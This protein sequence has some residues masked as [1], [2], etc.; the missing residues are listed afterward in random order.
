MWCWWSP[1]DDIVRSRFSNSGGGSSN[2]LLILISMIMVILMIE[3]SQASLV[4]VPIVFWP[5]I[6]LNH[7][8]GMTRWYRFIM[9]IILSSHYHNHVN[10]ST[11]IESYKLVSIVNMIIITIII[12]I[13]IVII[14]VIV[15]V[16]IMITIII[17]IIII[18]VII[19]I[20]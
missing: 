12:I 7:S 10:N 19:I 2:C 4:G 9:I 13:T 20:Y 11:M 5:L 16:I 3:G 8:Q 18:I 1:C 6:L 14:I 17:I 15:I